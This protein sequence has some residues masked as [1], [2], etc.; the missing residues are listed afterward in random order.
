MKFKSWKI[1]AGVT[2]KITIIGVNKLHKASYRVMPDRIEAGTYLCMS[3]ITNGTIKIK[4]ANPK[5]LLEVIYKLKE[6]G[7]KISINQSCI[8]LKAPKKLKSTNVKTSVYP[9]FPTDMQPIFTSILA[10]AQGE[11]TV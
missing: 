5:D 10:K 2:S 1:K 9:G 8:I 4:N 7:C 3:A 11:S 6:T